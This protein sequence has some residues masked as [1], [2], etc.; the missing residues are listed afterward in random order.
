[1]NG[2][3]ELPTIPRIYTAAAQW[4][5]VMIFVQVLYRQRRLKGWR[6]VLACLGGLALLS[7][8]LVLTENLPVVF[9]IP[10]MA[11]SMAIMVGILCLCCDLTL[12]SAGYCCVRAFLISELAA[13]LSWQLYYFYS[14]YLVGELPVYGYLIPSVV[15]FLAVFAL[16]WVLE[17]R[18][19]EQGRC[20]PVRLRSFLSVLAIG[21]AAFV[22]SNLSFV[23]NN[24]P[25]T[26]QFAIEI[27][28]IRT[29]VDGG[30]V[31]ILYAFHMQHRELEMKYELDAIHNVLET[32]YVQY[33]QSRESIEVINRKYHDLKHQIAALRKE[34]DP[35]RRGEWL[36]AM[37]SDIA[38]YEAQNKTGNAV[39]DT[40]LTGKSL[41]CQKH[42]INFTCVA[43]GSVL[44][45]LDVMD[46]C[47]IF[48]NALDNAI[49][50]VLQLPDKEQRLIHLSVSAQKGFL[51]ILVENYYAGELRFENGLP[52]ST[53]GDDKFHGFGVK[54]IRYSAAR[55]G[56]TVSITTENHWFHL[57][58]L[59]PLPSRKKQ[60]IDK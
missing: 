16:Q 33:R 45:F 13:S 9:W 2:G 29:L 50:A 8:E 5:S 52:L 26:S 55:Y 49:E 41:Y 1:M 28:N 42:G 51:L 38:V 23:T 17:R 44:K 34:S 14:A 59:I 57:K 12:L 31:A 47:T 48:G 36:D 19:C 20:E 7:A 18:S 25:F 39:L 58:I 37:E 32:Q 3:V 15:A 56:G 43:D 35:R 24:T 4:M 40:V 21:I 10:S 46:I 27:Y 54:S 22:V 60:K 11:G 6:N 30:G 53:K